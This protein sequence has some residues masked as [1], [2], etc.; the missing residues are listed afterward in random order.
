MKIRVGGETR[1]AI[2]NPC[3]TEEFGTPLNQQRTAAFACM[4][5]EGDEDWLNYRDKLVFTDSAITP[6]VGATKIAVI[7]YDPNGVR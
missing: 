3:L 5:M 2:Q 6:D 4:V 1:R 7:I